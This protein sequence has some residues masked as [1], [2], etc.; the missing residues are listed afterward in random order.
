MASSIDMY[1]VHALLLGGC[2]VVWKPYSS[3]Y[4]KRMAMK[5]LIFLRFKIITQQLCWSKNYT[6][7]IKYSKKIIFINWRFSKIANSFF[8]ECHQSFLTSNKEISGGH[9]LVFVVIDVNDN[10]YR[11]MA[12]ENSLLLE[13]GKKM[14]VCYYI[15]IL[16]NKYHIIFLLPFIWKKFIVWMLCRTVWLSRHNS[17][18]GDVRGSNS[19]CLLNLLSTFVTRLI[20]DDDTWW[21][22]QSKLIHWQAIAWHPLLFYCIPF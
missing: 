22:N 9:Q 6:L 18:S 7:Y 11:L 2:L 14:R 17:K 5:N 15:H 12:P 16:Q 21:Q 10:K 20:R 19:I 13:R 8:I 4:A 3:F 1:T